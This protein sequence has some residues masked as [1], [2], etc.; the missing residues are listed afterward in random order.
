MA[1]RPWSEGDARSAAALWGGDP[2][3]LRWTGVEPGQ[4][5]ARTLEWARFTRSES[6]AG[7]GFYFVVLVDG[8]LA[9]ACDVR[10]PERTDPRIG[11]LGYL[12]AE[13]FRGRG[14]MTAA[15]SLLIGWSFG[16][17][18]SLARI[19]ALTHPDNVRSA[20]VLERLGFAR[21]GLLRAYR[22]AC[23]GR[24]DRVMWSLLPVDWR[25]L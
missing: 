2:E 17:P 8:A 15:L 3:I 19:Q 11:E 18:L 4:S 13:R 10:L 14:V 5:V 21:E 6:A 12:L 25:A 22:P 23:E 16:S 1:L 7:R 9:G 20:R 24:E